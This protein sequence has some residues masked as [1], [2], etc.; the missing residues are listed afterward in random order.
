MIFQEKGFTWYILLTDQNFIVWLPLLLDILGNMSTAIACFPDCNARNFQSNLSNQA[1]FLHHQKIKTKIKIPW[2]RK[3]LL[4]WNKKTF[5]IL[6]KGR[7]VAKNCLRLDS[8]SIKL[9]HKKYV[10]SCSKF[11]ISFSQYRLLQWP[12]CFK[13]TV[14]KLE[15]TKR[16]T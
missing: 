1:V 9:I 10:R 14:S 2:E 8:A 4:R 6:F 7:S 16:S 13:Q 11:L 3:E 12:K 15:Q 5:F